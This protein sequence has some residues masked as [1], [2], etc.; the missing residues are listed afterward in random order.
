MCKDAL[1][2]SL[3]LFIIV[4][5]HLSQIQSKKRAKS[6]AGKLEICTIIP[7]VQTLS[8]EFTEKGSGMLMLLG[9]GPSTRPKA[10]RLAQATAPT[11][12]SLAAVV[13][14]LAS[15]TFNHCY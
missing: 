13:V 10:P 12:R 11:T 9:H 5:R 6:E 15:I 8:F 1:L 14:C 4:N 2:L 3:S 7:R